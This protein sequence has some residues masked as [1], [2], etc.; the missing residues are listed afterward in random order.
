MHHAL[1]L[2]ARGLGRV[3]PNPAV[4]CIIVD[5]QGRVVGRGWTQAG[6]RPHA[7]TEALAEA[8]SRARGA[9]A[10]VT[11]EPCAHR[12]KTPPCAEALVRAGVKRV[13][14][15]MEDPDPRVNGAGLKRLRDAGVAVTVGVLERE[16]RRL[17]EGFLRR[18]R[19]GRPSVTLKI[20][21]SLDGR[22]ALAS[23]ESRWI[24][25]ERSRAFGHLLRAQYDAII[26]GI[27]TALADDPMLT[28]RLDGL[29]DRSP[30]RIVLDTNARLPANSK[31]AKTARETPT[32]LF[33]MDARARPDLT[34]LGVE[35]VA[36][37]RGT[38]AQ[39][40]ISAMLAELGRRGVTRLLVEG[41]AR[42]HTSF[43]SVG[44]VDRL[45]VFTAPIVL[46]GDALSAAAALALAS[47]ETAP[48]FERAGVLELGGDLLES[49]VRKA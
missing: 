31:L 8:A 5:D 27:G 11:L 38:N 20:A 13:V 18:V 6:G 32:L 16:A 21:Q 45:E 41:G 36:V 4:G 9:T 49:F 25:G 48:H 29:E 12:G 28:C 2:A 30:L 26:I 3:S 14:A 44:L 47:L 39:I 17:N 19:D 15:A 46:G 43:L 22:T 23:G 33:T 10:Y 34:A 42:V 7:E 24:T 35:L 37:P 40:D 1:A